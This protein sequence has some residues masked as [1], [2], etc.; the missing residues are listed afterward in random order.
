MAILSNGKFSGFLCSVKE[1]G[2]KLKNGAKAMVEDF[3][4]GFNGHGWK[5]WK[6]GD[7]WRLELDELLVRKSFQVFE[8][9]INQITSIK[10]SQAITQGHAKIKEVSVANSD[11]YREIL[12]ETYPEDFTDPKFVVQ[13][14]PDW[15]LS[16]HKLVINTPLLAEAKF[17]ILSGDTEKMIKTAYVNITNVVG[18]IF[19]RFRSQTY[20]IHTDII[21]SDWKSYNIGSLSTDDENDFFGFIFPAGSSATITMIP[22]SSERV[23]T[24][25]K[26]VPCYRIQIEEEL[27]SITEYDLLRCQKGD[28]F[29]YV[30]VG[31]VFQYYINI[32]ISEFNADSE[33]GTILN[34]PSVGD[35]LVQFG[36]VSHQDKYAS[37]HSAIYLHVDDNE[38]AIDL[39]TDIYSKDWSKGNILKTRLG[40]NLPGTDGD[41]GLYSVNGKL[42]FVDEQGD[43]VSVI[44]PD[45]SASFARGKL[46]WTKDGSPS[47]SGTILLST[48]Q[49][50]VWEV[51]EECI[52]II[53]DKQGRRIEIDSNNSDIKMFTSGNKISTILEGNYHF[54]LESLFESS[55]T[56]I[57]IKNIPA[58]Y[59]YSSNDTMP[60]SVDISNIFYTSDDMNIIYS[61][62]M[63][64][65]NNPAPDVKSSVS[66]ILYTY[67]DKELT[68]LT[69]ESLLIRLVNNKPEYEYVVSKEDDYNL[70]PKGYHIIRVLYNA[71]S[72]SILAVPI[73]TARLELT[74][75]ISRYFANGLALGD[76]INNIASFYND[77]NFH[78]N[79]L[80]T[81]GKYGLKIDYS[82]I[83]SQNNG[84]WGMIPSVLCVGR[85][86]G[87]SAGYSYL[88]Y[89]TFDNS[90]MPSKIRRNGVGWVTISFPDDWNK[91][92]LG[93][94]NA[95][96]ILTAIGTA[97]VDDIHTWS[98]SPMKATFRTWIVNPAGFDVL[99]SDDATR[100][101]G[102]FMFEVKL[103]Q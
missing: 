66:I 90:I 6:R 91:F 69:N 26:N 27:N 49:N 58:S 37:R 36:N 34:P 86:S 54:T 94:D 17:G 39:M 28:K 33:T 88:T 72:N 95:Y 29:Y 64:I 40:G 93:S 10:G 74:G 60:V 11:V 46:S 83:L 44:N 76:S 75:Y 100:N 23:E 55:K 59:L 53:G 77:G 73:F 103:L 87:T 32:P 71:I 31:S 12:Q 41:R 67:S 19:F 8:L 13:G 102:D 30:Q 98:E 48:K 47:F 81:N 51:T 85:V 14:N 15:D 89:R 24:I 42:L 52:N 61:Y 18:E 21:N 80:I 2:R 82:R 78:I 45:G 50:K 96:V 56:D 20:N 3:L 25:E 84:L 7:S 16:S 35:E 99:L 9:I 22:T 4:S 63:Q 43:T 5:L 1:S 38:P 68:N 97:W 92:G 101:D 62:N 57:V 79:G 70:I 65:N